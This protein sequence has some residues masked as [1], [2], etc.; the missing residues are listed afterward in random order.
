M[1]PCNTPSE[2]LILVKL[3]DNSNDDGECWPSWAHIM[4]Q[5]GCSRSTVARAITQFENAGILTRQRRKN[6]T[7]VYQ[8]VLDRPW[9]GGSQDETYSAQGK[10]VAKRNSYNDEAKAVLEVWHTCTGGYGNVGRIRKAMRPLFDNHDIGEICKKL[11]IYLKDQVSQ[12]KA[13]YISPERFVSLFGTF[14]VK[15]RR[16]EPGGSHAESVGKSLSTTS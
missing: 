1:F 7:T 9:L 4:N 12:G 2:K 15:K 16:W 6:K 14:Q 13:Q 10:P 11:E 5:T 3:A 8:F